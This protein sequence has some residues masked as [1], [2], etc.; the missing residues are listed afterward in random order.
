MNQKPRRIVC[1]AM[2]Y[3]DVII[4]S[5][6]HYDVVARSALRLAKKAILED[7]RFKWELIRGAPS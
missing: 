4:A 6:R 3:G 1:A 2:R 7:P 5:P